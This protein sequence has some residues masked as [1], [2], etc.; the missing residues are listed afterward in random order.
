MCQPCR[1]EDEETRVGSCP[2]TGAGDTD[3]GRRSVGRKHENRVETQRGKH[4]STRQG[5]G[6]QSE[7]AAR[8]G[9]RPAGEHPEERR[10]SWHPPQTT[11]LLLLC[12]GS[13]R[14]PRVIRGGTA[15]ERIAV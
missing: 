13:V 6:G 3:K 1:G 9:P 15:T 2:T 12:W 10:R 11:L 7:R 14:R 4:E 8:S 5:H